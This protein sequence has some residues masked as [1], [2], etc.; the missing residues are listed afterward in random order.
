MSGQA[1]S[2]INKCVSVREAAK[3]LASRR[4]SSGQLE[5]ADLTSLEKKVMALK[6]KHDGF[7]N[8][9]ACLSQWG[10]TWFNHSTNAFYCE[11]CACRLNMANRVDARRLYGHDLCTD[12]S[13][14]IQL[15]DVV[16][17]GYGPHRAKWWVI[18]IPDHHGNWRAW[19][20]GS[21]SFGH[22]SVKDTGV[23]K[24]RVNW[25]ITHREVTDIKYFLKLVEEGP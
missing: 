9:G 2:G 14:E 25:S 18:D 20:P 13:L 22:F 10:V 5:R 6:G 15:F 3:A 19:K 24:G 12:Q 1:H 21:H 17:A 23:H 16:A 4:W 11:S 8:R 7:C